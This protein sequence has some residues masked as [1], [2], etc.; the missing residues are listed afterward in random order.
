MKLIRNTL[1]CLYVNLFMVI[2]L[3][4]SLF[5]GLLSNNMGNWVQWLSFSILV[6]SGILNVI[7][8]VKNILSTLE[9]Y[10]NNEYNG[11]R[12]HMR[13]IKFGLIPYFIFN[14]IIYFLLFM[15]LL[16]ASHGI[17]L[18]S[19][20]PLIFVIPGFFTYLTVLF[21]SSYGI[22]FLLILNKGKLINKKR[23]LIYI[24]LQFCFILDEIS[25]VIL[26]VKYK[27]I[28]VETKSRS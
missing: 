18:F 11:L 12:R 6:L 2:L 21:T 10:R 16:A 9:L 13:V 7:F 15:L 1:F 22:G 25:T 27:K 24:L 8:A 20:I 3:L 14:F 23:L 4:V 19:P 26:L 5:W 28:E 17:F